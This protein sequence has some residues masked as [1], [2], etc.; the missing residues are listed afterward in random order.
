MNTSPK[1]ALFSLSGWLFFLIVSPAA[2]AEVGAP[3]PAST[4][5]A[6]SPHSEPLI[7]LLFQSGLSSYDNSSWLGG[8]F[9]VGGRIAGAVWF[10]ASAGVE[11]RPQSQATTSASHLTVPATFGFRRVAVLPQGIEIRGGGD[12]VLMLEEGLS[13]DAVE[14]TLRP[15]PGGL[16]E[17][18]LAVPLAKRIALDLAVS[19]GAVL[20][21]QPSKVEELSPL[22]GPDPR[23]QLRFGLRFG[24]APKAQ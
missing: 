19:L 17:I 18:G 15:R 13:P 7:R 11:T 10:V 14:R 5:E 3:V 16:L 1:L 24:I 23:F 9:S 22:V 12:F 8:T 2:A 6:S 20:R 21:E 4:S